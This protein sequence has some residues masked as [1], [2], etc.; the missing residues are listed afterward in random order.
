MRIAQVS[1]LHEPVPPTAYGG[2]ERIVSY[3]TEE[4][5]R[6]GH[7][8]TLFAS[9]DSITRARLV[10]G[11]PRSLRVNH[12][13]IDPVV[14]HLVMLDRVFQEADAFNVIHFHIDY[15]H[16]PLTARAAVP[17]L[18][19]LH[20][21]LDVD[22]LEQLYKQFPDTPVV[23]ISNSQRRPLPHLN[24]QATVYHGL[25][26]D[27]YQSHPVAVRPEYLVFIGR[28]SPE[29]RPDRAIAIA[30]AVGMDLKIAAKVSE[31][32]REYFKSVVEPL[33]RKNKRLVEFVGEV[34]DAEKDELLGNAT[35]LLFPVDWPEPFGLVIVES[36]ACGTPVVAYPMGAVPEV[37]QHGT[38]G[39]LVQSIDEAVDA[40]RNVGTIDRAIVRATFERCFTAS[41]MADNY[42]EAYTH[43]VETGLSLAS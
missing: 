19:T 43:L 10:S 33:L 16:Y 17:T 40:V 11:W 39:F 15:L 6:R 2:T 18:T 25:P 29:K 8:V 21:R 27:L 12:P 32:D 35:A 9:G 1:P 5:V 37:V 31:A 4:L 14:P 24:W 13:G 36:M 38:T 34:S 22:G 7:D 23:S 3:L 20:G 30:R 28:I 42:L 26:Q 41:R